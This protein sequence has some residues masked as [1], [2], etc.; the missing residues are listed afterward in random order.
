MTGSSHPSRHDGERLGQHVSDRSHAQVTAHRRWIGV[1]LVGLRNAVAA[2]SVFA[3]VFAVAYAVPRYFVRTNVTGQSSGGDVNGTT[4][5]PTHDPLSRRSAPEP[6]PGDITIGLNGSAVTYVLKGEQYVEGG[7]HAI[8]PT[9]GVLTSKITV[10]G[11][12]DTATP[13]DYGIRYAVRDSQGHAATVTRTVK[14]V[15]SMDTQSAGIPVLMYHYVYDPADPPAD[16]NAN[17]IPVTSLEQQLTYL[18]EHDFYF[19]SWAEVSAFIDGTHSL[20]AR[21][22]VLTFDD[23]EPRFFRYGEPML[24]KY[25]VPA[26]SFV[27]GSDGD[28]LNKMKQH[29]SPYLE[30]ESHSFDMHR[31]GGTVGHGGRISAMTKDEIVADLKQSALVTG[32]MQAFAYPFGDTTPDAQA[33]VA[34]AGV[35][36]AFT[37]AYGWA[38]VGDDPTLLPRVRI[39][40]DG[41]LDAFA[42]A[43]Q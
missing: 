12:V 25:R 8:E 19:P 41:T 30:Y 23:G 15:E 28:A 14:V 38:M 31:A 29:A 26:T 33:A 9:D 21:S 6:D 39:Q 16:L 22:V 10:S 36:L 35:P 13:G 2:L 5:N 7:A 27:I 40:G 1:A 42:A 18:T 34:E 4:T 37:T 24:T 32:S 20:P 3:I 11:T 43:I 17:F